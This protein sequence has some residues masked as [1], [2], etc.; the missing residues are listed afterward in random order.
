MFLDDLAK[1]RE[2]LE[3]E[4]LRQ[5]HLG[6]PKYAALGREYPMRNAPLPERREAQ[7]FVDELLRCG[8]RASLGG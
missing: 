8:F 7:V 6:E 5:H 4:V 3:V 1:Q 2:Y